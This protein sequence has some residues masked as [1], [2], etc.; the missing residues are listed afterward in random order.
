MAFLG[1]T[2]SVCLGENRASLYQQQQRQAQGR[3]DV[4]RV[5]EDWGAETKAAKQLFG[6]GAM[7]FLCDMIAISDS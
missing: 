2:K 6:L 5:S 7:G 4:R 1:F 3:Q